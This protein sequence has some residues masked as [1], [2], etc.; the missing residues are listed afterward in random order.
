M[1]R[2][3]PAGHPPGNAI[4]LLRE[5][6]H[7]GITL[8][9]ALDVEGDFT[10]AALD[11]IRVHKPALLR[12]LVNPYRHVCMSHPQRQRVCDLLADAYDTD[13][14]RCMELAETW[15]RSLDHLRNNAHP[16]P[17]A[18]AWTALERENARPKR[19]DHADPENQ[20]Q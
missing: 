9:P 8:R 10:D 17:D 12:L 4:D 11:L 15:Y 20:E 19:T 18:A 2:T 13:P 14:L 5:L 16:D 1:K 7:A 6:Q 3:T